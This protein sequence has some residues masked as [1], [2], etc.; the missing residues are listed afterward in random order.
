MRVINPHGAVGEVWCVW[1]A[2]DRQFRD[3]FSATSLEKIPV[4]TAGL[5]ER[6]PSSRA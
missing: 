3:A 1:T 5:F 2:G 6:D 4:A